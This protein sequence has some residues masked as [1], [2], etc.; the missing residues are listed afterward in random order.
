MEQWKIYDDQFAVSSKGVVINLKTRKKLTPSVNY[1]GYVYVNLFSKEKRENKRLHRLM[2][3]LFIPNPNN[4]PLVDH[5]NGNKVDNRIENLRWCSAQTNRAN[6]KN[7]FKK[8]F[9]VVE[10]SQI[11][12][13]YQ[14]GVPM[15]E[16]ATKND[17]SYK[18]IL[19]IIN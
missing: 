14:E 15:N 12:K 18:H 4:L 13:D 3:E 2:A 16:I 1:N 19:K 9:S 11:K 5:I 7:D 17:T 10:I 8:V 6:R